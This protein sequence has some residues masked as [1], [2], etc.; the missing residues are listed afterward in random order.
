MA[1]WMDELERLGELRDKG[2]LT[3]EEFEAEK[4]DLLRS[5]NNKTVDLN[6]TK[7]NKESVPESSTNPDETNLENDSDLQQDEQKYVAVLISTIPRAKQTD[8]LKKLLSERGLNKLVIENTPSIPHAL[9][10]LT[11]ED[12]FAFKNVFEAAGGSVCLLTAEG[13]L[14][15]SFVDSFKHN[16]FVFESQRPAILRELKNRNLITNQEFQAAQLNNGTEKPKGEIDIS[17]ID[18]E[19]ALDVKLVTVGFEKNKTIKAIQ[20]LKALEYEEA[21]TLVNSCP[22]LILEGTSK[23]NAE[24]AKSRLETFGAVVAITL[25]SGGFKE[26]LPEEFEDKSTDKG[27]PRPK[28]KCSHCG[29]IG[30]CY[31]TEKETWRQDKTKQ[32]TF[33]GTRTIKQEMNIYCDNCG[34]TSTIEGSSQQKI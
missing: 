26:F 32:G 7:P 33:W 30:H 3:V 34:L 22:S 20:D 12:S 28:I 6:E 9:R 15:S 25:S 14:K 21:R 29:V 19:T 27:Y 11:K 4:E 2:L 10:N 17:N 1:E 31:Q 8:E 24:T 23:L 13:F 5:R 18:E 16:E